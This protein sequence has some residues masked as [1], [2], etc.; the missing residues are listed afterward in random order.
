MGKA[1]RSEVEVAII[2]KLKEKKGRANHNSQHE[3]L[4][5]GG[6]YFRKLMSCFLEAMRRHI[7]GKI[8]LAFG[9][10]DVPLLSMR[11]H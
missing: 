8:G 4:N 11:G 3:S 7:E 10:G 5:H 6:I 1:L 2:E 9:N